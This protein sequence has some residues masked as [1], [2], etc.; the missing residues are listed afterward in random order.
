MNFMENTEIHEK[1]WFTAGFWPLIINK[2]TGFRQISELGLKQGENKH[3]FTDKK[4][5]FTINTDLRVFPLLDKT[6]I[7]ILEREPFLTILSV[8][9][10]L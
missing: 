3:G 4:H 5:G 8:L 6:V 10:V 7:F 2:N 1:G 9:S